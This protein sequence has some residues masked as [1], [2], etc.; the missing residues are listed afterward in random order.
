MSN[1]SIG[2]LRIVPCDQLDTAAA[3][4]A[5]EVGLTYDLRKQDEDGCL[6]NISSASDYSAS[7]VL[8]SLWK[9]FLAGI[10]NIC[11]W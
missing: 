6:M 7:P 8:Q 4:A 3:N 2:H 1:S 10:W 11:L 5:K 9:W